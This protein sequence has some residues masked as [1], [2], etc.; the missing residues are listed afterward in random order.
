MVTFNGKCTLTRHRSI[1]NCYLLSTLIVCHKAVVDEFELWHSKLGHLNYCDL[2]RFLKVKV[3]RGV[4]NLIKTRC[5]VLI[6]LES[7]SSHLV[8]LKDIQ[9][10]L[11][12][13]KCYI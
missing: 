7:K 4:P 10:L 3:V 8:L 12:F 11:V 13:L 1:G 5:V 6:N 9:L 2:S